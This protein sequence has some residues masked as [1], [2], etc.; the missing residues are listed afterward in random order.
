MQIPF[1]G[2]SLLDYAINASL[3]ISNIAI[4]KFDKAGLITFQDTIGATLPA[5]N[6]NNQMTLIQEIYIK[7]SLP[8]LIFPVSS[9]MCAPK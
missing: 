5:G 8:S 7:N 2:M 4:R 1:Q 3:V 9:P 6:R